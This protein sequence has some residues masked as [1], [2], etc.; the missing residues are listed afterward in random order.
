LIP[1]R[2]KSFSLLQGIQTGSG[3]HLASY[4]MG[5]GGCFQRNKMVVCEAD[6]LS[7]SNVNVKNSWS[8]T[9]TLSYVFMLW[10]LIEYRAF[11]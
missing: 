1:G 5:I 8:Y 2:S 10:W 11:V 3:S 7:T 4:L 6:H 9:S